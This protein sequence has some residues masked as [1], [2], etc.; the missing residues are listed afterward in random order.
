MLNLAVSLQ[1]QK[2]LDVTYIANDGFLI[3]SHSGSVMIDALFNN[4]FGQYDVPSEKLRADIV[5]GQPPFRRVDLYL[6]THSHGDHFYAPYV[7]DFMKSHPETRLV[8]CP[9]VCE[10]LAAGDDLDKRMKVVDIEFGGRAYVAARGV[11]L[12]IWRL[13]HFLDPSGVGCVSLIYLITLDGFGI[14]HLGDAPIDF[15]RAD[16]ERLGLDKEKIDVLFLGYSVLD[17]KSRR[18]I[19]KVIRPK[20]IIAM[21]IPPKD[22]EVETKKFVAAYPNAV[23]FR[24]PLETRSFPE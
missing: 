9:Q 13:K 8:S 2:A 22:I 20:H 6:V 5:G 16:Y 18:F 12:E 23:V 24:A 15:N 3:S 17:E 11:S 7:L 1:A 19:Q 21:H 4:G 10:S 14:L